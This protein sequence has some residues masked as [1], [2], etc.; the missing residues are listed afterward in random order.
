ML[1]I[2]PIEDKETQ[3]KTALLCKVEY[4]PDTLAY[5]AY[6]DGS[7]AGIVQFKFTTEGGIIYNIGVTGTHVETDYQILFTLGRAALNFTDLCGVH[8]AFF[9]GSVTDESLITDIGFSK[10]EKGEWY[11]NLEGFF[12]SGHCKGCK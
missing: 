3:E 10:N 4:I 6:S 1:K 12:T 8:D 7:L 2:L 9:Y 5:S 11:M